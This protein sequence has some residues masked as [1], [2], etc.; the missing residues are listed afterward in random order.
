MRLASVTP[1]LGWTSYLDPSGSNFPSAGRV[2][3]SLQHA[4]PRSTQPVEDFSTFDRS[5]CLAFPIKWFSTIYNTVVLIGA[6]CWSRSPL[7]KLG[8][9][10]IFTYTLECLQDLAHLGNIK[11]KAICEKSTMFVQIISMEDLW[12]WNIVS[13]IVDLTDF[14]WDRAVK[15]YSDVYL[16]SPG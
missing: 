5:A 2:M 6:A 13:Q 10:Q 9:S 3:L 15:S 16:F 11:K 1:D 7:T 8:F 14:L 12:C 4:M